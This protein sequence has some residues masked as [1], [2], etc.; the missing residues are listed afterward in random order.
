MKKLILIGLLALL[1]INAQ[2]QKFYVDDNIPTVKAQIENW[3][4][5]NGYSVSVAVPDTGY[6]I[7]YQKLSISKGKKRVFFQL[8]NVVSSS[9]DGIASSKPL[10]KVL[11]SDYIQVVDEKFPAILKK[12]KE[13]EKLK[14]T[15][16]V[17]YEDT[18]TVTREKIDNI[19][20]VKFKFGGVPA[21]RYDVEI[22][23][24]SAGND[25]TFN[26]SR[27]AY[28]RVFNGKGTDFYDLDLLIKAD[29]TIKD[30]R[31][32]FFSVKYKKSTDLSYTGGQYLRVIV[33]VAPPK[34][35]I[36]FYKNDVMLFIGT[37]LDPNNSTN[38]VKGLS[39]E[40]S[41]PFQIDDFTWMRIG[42]YLHPNF[43]RDSISFA[44]T[45]YFKLNGRPLVDKISYIGKQNSRIDIGYQ[46][47]SIGLY[48]DIFW[49][50]SNKKHTFEDKNNVRVSPFIHFEW[51][52]R[53][54]TPKMAFSSAKV[55][56]LRYV[57]AERPERIL[58][59]QPTSENFLTSRSIMTQLY[60]TAGT[61]VEAHF[62]NVYLMFQQHIG[63]RQD[64][65]NRMIGN[66][67]EV[68]TSQFSVN[69][70]LAVRIKEVFTLSADLKDI[71]T[72]QDYV[73]ISFGIPVNL[74]DALKKKE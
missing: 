74:T 54:K 32:H 69:I 11:K 41:V 5:S 19:R 61:T 3:L 42:A 28:T 37:T 50:L 59:E 39:I 4:V 57:L 12:L 73:N 64:F 49:P 18:M 14:K 36:P 72:K 6:K 51:A 1:S 2:S 8:E 68:K 34:K 71:F 9:I 53:T 44:R 16:N 52:R 25:V 29:T 56:T 26:S 70:R 55:D 47:E 35:T 46:I 27:G 63:Y 31:E 43:S 38:K 60:F 33:N 10:R 30:K 58:D 40:A 48:T 66:I 20:V 45:D 23:Q 22:S 67:R 13:A 24:I 62:P 65:I 21:D 7:N 17:F 15:I